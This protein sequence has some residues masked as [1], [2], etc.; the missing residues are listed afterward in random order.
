MPI[1]R[2]IETRTR[3]QNQFC[4]L[5][6]VTVGRENNG[7]ESKTRKVELMAEPHE[8]G[9]LLLR[10]KKKGD[11]KKAG[12][13]GVPGRPGRY[14]VGAVGSCVRSS[15]PLRLH[16]E[17]GRG[18]LES[19]QCSWRGHNSLS[20]SQLQTS[21]ADHQLAVELDPRGACT[22]PGLT[23]PAWWAEHGSVALA[24]FLN[25]PAGAVQSCRAEAKKMT[26]FEYLIKTHKEE[27]S[28]HQ[29]AR[30]DPLAQM[31]E[32]FL[33]QRDG[34]LG[35]S[36][37]GVLETLADVQGELSEGACKW[38]TS[39]STEDTAQDVWAD[40]DSHPEVS[41]GRAEELGEERRAE[42]ATIEL[43]LCTES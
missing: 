4:H 40:L 2:Q 37:Q 43:C 17:A 21:L 11:G 28:K 16:F 6:K 23:G 13:P 35:S 25:C 24:A 29:A 30:K 39:G 12:V 27:S 3:D 8:G 42:A 41:S 15:W 5:C 34:A 9:C 10:D 22:H 7:I 14:R 32:G 31:E 36:A 33:Q 1:P 20:R 19:P 18:T 38:G 26:T